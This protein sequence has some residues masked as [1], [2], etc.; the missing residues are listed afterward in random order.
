MGSGAYCSAAGVWTNA[1]SKAYKEDIIPLALDKALKV[2]MGLNPV[3]FRSKRAPDERHVGFIAEEVPELVATKDRT[4]L[5]SMDIVA[6]LT[7]VVQQQQQ[8]IQTLKQ[9]VGKLKGNL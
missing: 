5:S 8:E 1:S 2:L 3:T 7:K 9:E 6:V 4:G